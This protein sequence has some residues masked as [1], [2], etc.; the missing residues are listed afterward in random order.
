M[1]YKYVEELYGH[2]GQIQPAHIVITSPQFDTREVRGRSFPHRSKLMPAWK[3]E[4]IAKI[5]KMRD[6]GMG[7]RD[8]AGKMNLEMQ[9]IQRWYNNNLDMPMRNPNRDLTLDTGV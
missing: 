2:P 5:K 9:H 4:R 1:V 8:I 6:D 7:W 3:I